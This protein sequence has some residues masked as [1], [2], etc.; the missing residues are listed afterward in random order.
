MSS[1]NLLIK[2]FV[3]YCF[4]NDYCSLNFFKSKNTFLSINSIINY[5]AIGDMRI[6]L[7]ISWFVYFQM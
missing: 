2:M 6:Q 5:Q 3:D 7:N 4:E 1:D